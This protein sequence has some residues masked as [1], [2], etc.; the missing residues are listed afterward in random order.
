MKQG[1][2]LPLHQWQVTRVV[3]KASRG[4]ARKTVRVMQ[5]NSG[6]C[7]QLLRR[8]VSRI[9]LVHEYQLTPLLTLSAHLKQNLANV[10]VHCPKKVA[11]LL[12]ELL[13][14][15]LGTSFNVRQL[16]SLNL[17]SAR[18]RPRLHDDT[19]TR[20]TL[21]RRAAPSLSE[22]PRLRSRREPGGPLGA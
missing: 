19:I 14:P 5:C 10:L 15:R 7:R 22:S 3:H 17:C 8:D 20:T 4:R 6:P 21:R 2:C 1:S 11:Y 13:L 16:V 12:H 18:Q 9:I